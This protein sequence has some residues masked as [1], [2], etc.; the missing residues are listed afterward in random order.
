MYYIGAAYY[1]ELWDKEEIK[2]DVDRMKSVG[3]NCVRVGEFAWSTMEKIE[4]VFDFE[5]FKYMADTLY[6]NGIYTILCTPSCTPPRWLFEK[7]PDAMRTKSNDFVK[8]QPQVHSRCHLCKSHKG[9]RE[10]NRIIAEQMAKAFANHPGVIGWQIDNELF[11]YDDG[12]FCESCAKGFREYL[13]N[14]YKTIENLNKKWGMYRWSL[15][16]TSFDQIEPPVINSWEN[17]SRRTEWQTFQNSLIYSYVEEQAEAIRKYSSTPIGT[18]MMNGGNELSYKEINKCLDVVQHNHYDEEKDLYKAIFFFDFCRTIKDVPFWVT[19]TQPGW[20]GGAGAYNG[21]RRP[22]HCYMNSLA[23]IAKGAEMNLYWLYRCHPNGHELGHGA[24]FSTAGRASSVSGAIKKLS[25]DLGKCDSFLSSTKVSSKIALTYSSTASISIRHAPIVAYL[26]H[27][28]KDTIIDTFYDA[29]RHYNVDVIETD[30]CLDGYRVIFSPVLTCIDEDGFKDRVIEWVKNG[31]T[32][33]VGP[34]S[35]I[36]TQ[37]TSKY[38]S[39]PYSTLEELCGVYTVYQIPMED[40][41]FK[42]R[43]SDGTE[44]TTALG[45]DA[46]QVKD[47]KSLATYEGFDLEGYTAVAERQLGKGK[48]I[49][50]GTAPDHDSLRRLSGEKPI[51]EASKNISLTERNGKENGI[52]VMEIENK[53][54]YIVL[55]KPYYEILSEK[56]LCGTV[57]VKPYT[58]LFLKEI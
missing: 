58:A 17:P 10:K 40:R 28:F 55:D 16:Y 26:D 27:H 34:L 53:E 1:P 36:M 8:V 50:L 3:I 33:I 47:A 22:E 23:P 14:K 7:Y 24:V 57:A 19:E 43:W 38:T 15:D 4:G 18:D 52:I 13:K 30:K 37:Y 2:K 45:C 9:V 25:Q 35:D 42:I 54:G 44:S 12:C 46:Y 11:T 20:N 6:E 32:W 51:L 49:L 41:R 31:G 29:F 5:L 56:T 21:Y 39:A 48:V